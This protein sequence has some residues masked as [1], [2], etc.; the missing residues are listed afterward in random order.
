MNFELKKGQIGQRER[1]GWAEK[2]L[3][4][5]MVGECWRVLRQLCLDEQLGPQWCLLEDLTLVIALLYLDEPKRMMAAGFQ[6]HP[7]RHHLRR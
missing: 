3:V 6:N 2:S 7:R 5:W 1:I 4:V